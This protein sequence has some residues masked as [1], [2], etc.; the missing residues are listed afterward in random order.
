MTQS[1]TD[2]NTCN[3]KYFIVIAGMHLAVFFIDTCVNAI[4]AQQRNERDIEYLWSHMFAFVV[5]EGIGISTGIN[6]STNLATSTCTKHRVQGATY[7]EIQ[8]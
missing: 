7:I 1:A 2:N 5:V 4:I 3:T 8:N 6:T